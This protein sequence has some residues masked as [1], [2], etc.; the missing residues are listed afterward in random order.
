M[1]C[2]AKEKASGLMNQG[3]ALRVD[4]NFFNYNL[5]EN[6]A[7]TIAAATLKYFNWTNLPNFVGSGDAIR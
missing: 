2:S 7:P 6:Y 5:F 3:S 4:N 1:K